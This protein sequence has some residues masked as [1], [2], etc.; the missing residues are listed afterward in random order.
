[1]KTYKI[2]V[3]LQGAGGTAWVTA[4][5]ETFEAENLVEAL[6][7]VAQDSQFPDND[8]VK[9]LGVRLEEIKE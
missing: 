3:R 8:L 9:T 1:M 7:I 6:K 4:T 5:P 2:E